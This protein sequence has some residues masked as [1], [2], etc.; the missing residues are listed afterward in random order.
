MVTNLA[1]TS[2]TVF[3]GKPAEEVFLH[4]GMP[5]TGSSTIQEFLA[6]NR[7]RF[8]SAGVAVPRSPGNKN[9]FKLAAY[10]FDDNRM[11]SVRKIVGIQN[12]DQIASFRETFVREFYAELASINAS[13][14]ILS[15]EH[16][17]TCYADDEISRLEALLRPLANRVRV[18]FYVRRQDDA[19]IARWSTAIKNGETVEH[20][21]MRFELYD[22][23]GLAERYAKHFG[24]ENVSVGVFEREQLKNHDLVDD[25]LSRVD[26]EF[27]GKPTE[28]KASNASLDAK[29]MEFLRRL[30]TY[31]PRFVEG[32]VSVRRTQALRLL[33]A[34]SNGPVATLPEEE[35]DA[36]FAKFS[37]GNSRLAREYLDRPD[38]VLFRRAHRTKDV[39]DPHSLS[40][41]EAFEIF[42]ELWSANLTGKS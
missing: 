11:P 37:E 1:Q 15:N 9:H 39:V 35:L 10:A 29:H 22:A 19:A 14:I 36:F 27:E 12:R 41:D 13:R 16:C 3:A 21:P 26:V 20:P 4:I 31:L 7:K 33:E 30:N 5:K 23:Y 6:A 32:R 42:A 28:V 34:M 38:G 24:R 18:F 40:I 8:A 17:A 25:F 2:G